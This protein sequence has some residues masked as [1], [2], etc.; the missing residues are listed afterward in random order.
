MTTKPTASAAKREEQHDEAMARAGEFV[1]HLLREAELRGI[2][3][4]NV[5]TILAMIVSARNPTLGGK[6]LLAVEAQLQKY[7]IVKIIGA[8]TLRPVMNEPQQSHINELEPAPLELVK[9]GD[10][11]YGPAD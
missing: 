6:V 9:Q 11:S 2:D 10:G 5:A 8:G 3:G 4:G 7:P 1:Q